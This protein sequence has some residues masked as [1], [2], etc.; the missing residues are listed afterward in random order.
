MSTNRLSSIVSLP[1]F[2]LLV[3]SV[4]IVLPYGVAEAITNTQSADIERDS[5]QYYSVSDANQ[6][7]LDLVGDNTI[8]AWVKPEVIYGDTFIIN[9]ADPAGGDVSYY[10]YINHLGQLEGR[11]SD[12]GSINTGH[13]IRFVSTYTFPEGEWHHIA[14]SFDISIGDVKAYIDGSEITLDLSGTMGGSIYNS[15]QEVLVGA[16][17]NGTIQS[18][19]DGLIDEVRVWNDVRTQTEVQDNRFATLSGSESG[20]VAYWQFNSTST[21]ATSN[22]ND[23]VLHNSPLYSEEPS[24]QLIC[25]YDGDTYGSFSFASIPLLFSVSCEVKGLF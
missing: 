22:G 6:T 19:Y 18:Y 17:K 14:V 8:E 23:L 4:T 12:N 25:V 1:T 16:R 10:L 3:L 5:G 24:H 11:Y 21:D 7:G 13:Y 2:V 20:L 9:K 15:A